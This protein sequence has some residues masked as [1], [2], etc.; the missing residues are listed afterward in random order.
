[1]ANST[2]NHFGPSCLINFVQL[3]LI[4]QHPLKYFTWETSNKNVCFSFYFHKALF[5]KMTNFTQNIESA[6]THCVE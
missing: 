4:V 2:L 3:H 1:M 6:I 5:L